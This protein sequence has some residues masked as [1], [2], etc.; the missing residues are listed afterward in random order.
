MDLKKLYSTLCLPLIISLLAMTVVTSCS[1]DNEEL[2][3]KY[4]YVQFKLYKTGTEPDASTRTTVD[5]LEHLSDAQ[6][7]KIVLIH[8]GVTISQT[9]RLNSYNAENAEFGL[10]S[11]KLQLLVGDY[12]IV[13]YYLYDKLD[14]LLFTGTASD[15]GTFTIIERGL[16]EKVLSTDVVGSGMINF[17]L[18]KDGLQ[19]RA[20]GDYL[21]KDINLITVTVMNTFNRETTVFEK[22][23]VTYK[24]D[25]KENTNE[26]NPDDKYMDIGTATCDS[27][28]WL[29]AGT[30]KV[31]GYVAYKKTGGKPTELEGVSYLESETFTVTDNQINKDVIVPIQLSATA[32]HIKDYIALKEIWESLGGP[33][34]SFYGEGYAA[35]TN[36]NFN[37]E[38]DMWGSQPGVAL[39]DKGRITS[40]S[41]E[42]FGAN[43]I[44]PD[45]IAQ[46]SELKV[47]SLGSHNEKLGGPIFGED[48]ATM[49]DEQKHKIRMHYKE[50]FLDYDPREN[51]SDMIK[52]SIN[53]DPGQKKIKKSSRITLKDTQIGQT[54]N[55]ITFISKGIM[56]LTKL[57]QFYIAN[58]PIK[59]EDICEQW[60]AEKFPET[61]GSNQYYLD[62]KDKG[63]EW[64]NMT[65]LIDVEVYNC[66]NMMK[67]PSFLKQL[68]EMQL[69]NV[70]CNKQIDA[71]QLKQ[72]WKD[73]ADSEVGP[74]I[75]ILYL[76]Y[77]NLTGFPEH[78]SLK[79]MEKLGYL[80]CVHNELKEVS[81]FGKEVKLATLMLDYNHIKD[82]PNDFCSFTEQVENLSFAHNELEY[83]PNI[84][85]A[86]LV[87]TM[88]SVDFSYNQIGKNGGKNFKSE[89]D[90]KG[91][92]AST[93]S[94]SYNKI[95]KFPKELFKTGSPI[96]TIDLSSNELTEV[97]DG[98]F[99][100]PKTGENYKNSNLLQIVDL[101]FNK[102]TK[103]SDDFRAT[104]L[105]YLSNMD[106]SYN[107][108]SE[109]PLAPLNSS[110]LKAFGIRHQRDEK[111]NRILRKWPEGITTCVSLIQFQIGSNDI[112]KVEEVMTPKL[113]IVDIK[114]NPN[115]SI[116]M[117]SVCPY[118][119]AGMYKLIY[120]KTQDIKGCDALDIKR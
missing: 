66:K 112:R 104:T 30:Y 98:A 99:K 103:L 102:L 23:K 50:K 15:D 114:D 65:E 2:Q 28:V 94:L 72:D 74:K 36:W 17:R 106:V 105:P 38:I 119:E 85:D 64:K 100:D 45:A 109:V 107:C 68:P 1:D 67:L 34:W 59:V 70:A 84:F 111:G 5:K 58:S 31:T 27:A 47:L 110:Q 41:I 57:Q 76:G 37:K 4:G 101:R 54:T 26:Y 22:L 71:E 40:I 60:E 95:S 90:Y 42:C 19:T 88:G 25:S 75:Q 11:E 86:N 62:N 24:E 92:N 82:I 120:D 93:V 16:Q 3:G 77:N 69:L 10:R 63:L 39:D 46:L 35:G 12:Q 52:E 80:D 8:D 73:L 13:G 43:G 108:F 53:M 44:V 20:E 33:K 91:I 87:Y 89:E 117:T 81:S 97:P 9:L 29:P 118:I 14:E 32:E 18:K 113:Y 7:I 21:F 83:I 48:A 61:A 79:R 115:I 6:K 116:D 55:N 96:T 56:A 78:E 49:S 51:L